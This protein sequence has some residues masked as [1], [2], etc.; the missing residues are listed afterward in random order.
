LHAV[1]RLHRLGE[2]RA[3]ALPAALSVLFMVAGLA[4][5]TARTAI[6]GEHQSQRDRNVKQ[7]LAAANAGLEAAL[8]RTNQM[9]PGSTQCAF[10]NPGTGTF[11][12]GALE[13]DGWCREQSEDLGNG[14][15]FTMRVSGAQALHANGQ[16]LS[17]RTVISTGA[18]NGVRRRLM[19]QMNAATGEPVFP[20]GYAGVSLDPI[21]LPNSVQV[22]GGVG[23]NGNVY[24]RNSAYV[25][26]TVTPGPGKTLEVRNTASVCPAA[27]TTPAQES[28]NLQPV[29]QGNAA[30]END[31]SRI[32]NPPASD[33]LDPCTDCDAST[34][35]PTTRMLRLRNNSTLTLGGGV[36]SFCGIEVENTA[37]LKVAVRP[38]GTGIRIFVDSPEHCGGAGTGSVTV[39][40][41][42][43]ILNLN[44][45]PT[46][47]QLYLVG[48]PA[49]ATQVGFYGVDFAGTMVMAVY[50]PYSTIVIRGNGTLS[51]A[52]A[53]KGIDLDNST[54][55]NY[56]ER[57][58]D[59]TTGNP[60]RLF[61]PEHYI[62]CTASP[63]GIAPDSGC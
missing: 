35:D 34:W 46:T 45:D 22:T 60:L 54:H 59:I 16:A 56:H 7:A 41:S 26:G 13:G 62:E 10:N 48:S 49:I 21:T 39:R 55:I 47:F 32:G 23:S 27:S 25:C 24:L 52:I 11:Q 28:F 8:Y 1:L 2:E 9:Q 3:I 4:T 12:V 44:S 43:T 19:L 38:L 63:T 51:G 30:T 40:N 5:L 33:S 58:A 42:A 18:V 14:T 20:N 37:Q 31:N 53:S 61:K 57:I 50:A 36:Y 29:D 6:G 17:R 15:S